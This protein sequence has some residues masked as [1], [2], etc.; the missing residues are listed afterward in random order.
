MEKNSDDEYEPFYDPKIWGPPNN[1]NTPNIN[2]PIINSNN[3][4]FNNTPNIE[5]QC[6]VMS[7]LFDGYTIL[8]KLSSIQ[9]KDDI[10][11]ILISSMYSLFLKHNLNGLI[12]H[13]E[14]TIFDIPDFNINY[15]RKY[16]SEMV[17]VYDTDELS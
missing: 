14:M 3:I 9:T 5:I 11:A 15:I 6:I 17:Y 16:P 2:T 4:N 7:H 10:I 8:I 12:K 1:T 13:L